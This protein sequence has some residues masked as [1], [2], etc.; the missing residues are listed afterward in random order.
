MPMPAMQV[1]FTGG[2]LSPALYARVDID[3]FSTGARTLKN[4]FVHASG[5][6]SNRTGL[7]YTVHC[8]EDDEVCRLI[9]FTFNTEQTYIL[10][11]QDQTMRVIK[12]DGIVLEP[13]FN[14]SGATQANP[15]VVTTS[16]AHGYA[17]GDEVFISGVGGMS[18]LNERFFIVA[19]VTATTFELQGIDGTSYTAYSSGGTVSRIF[20][21]TTPY[22]EADLFDLKFTQ[23]GDVMTLVHPSYAP[24]DL[25]RTA[26]YIWTLAVISFSPD[27]SAPTGV[28]AA[29]SGTGTGKAYS[30]I[31]TAY[32]EDTGEESIASSAASVSNKDLSNSGDYCTITWS[33]VTDATQYNIYKDEDGSGF[34]GF[35]GSSNNLTFTDRNIQP[36]YDDSPALTTRNPFAAA[37]DY[38]ATT[39][40]HQQR[41]WF[42]QT[43]NDPQKVFGSVSG[44][45]TNMNVSKS[46]RDDD[47]VSA[48]IAGQQINEIRHLVA[49]GQMIVFTAGAEWLMTSSSQSKGLTPSTISFNV[50][51]YYGASDVRPLVIGNTALFITEK[52]N[53]VR[54]INYSLETDGYT[55][56]ELTVLAEHLF[57]DYEI[58]DWTYA[59]APY[60]MV[61]AVRDDGKVLSLTYV[62]EHQVW[63]WTQHDTSGTFESVASVTEG[64]EDAV[65]FVVRRK[66]NGVWKKYI[67]RLHT[68][69]FTDVRDCFFVDSGVSYDN[70]LAV[71]GA[72]QANPVVVTVTGHNY[73]NGDRIDLTDIVGMDELNGLRFK[74]NNVTANTFELQT[75][76]AVPVDIDGTGYTA[77]E[78]GGYSRKAVD[79]VVGLDHLEGEEVSI[80]A[81]GNVISGKTVANGAVSLG[82]YYS[83]VH[84]GLG[85]VSDFETLDVNLQDKRG[86]VHGRRR[87]VKE[88]T[89]RWY[90]SRGGFLGGSEDDLYEIN[91]REFEDWGDPTD[92]ITGDTRHNVSSAWDTSGKLFYRQT[93]PLP[94][95]ILAIIPEV[96]VGDN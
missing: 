45:Y 82:N 51:T 27:I 3:K 6:V 72:T 38:P 39:A 12:D 10:A 17:N 53:Q 90:K 83:R 66:V 23:S 43:D 85:Y 9:P 50:Q 79:S 59:Q 88:A 31:V 21:L 92:L 73:S 91:Q 5:G 26:H 74:V 71:S 60:S 7:K 28:G 68:R 34:Y 1:A 52:A 81:D 32:N 33:S 94:V 64:Q 8:K 63:A 86:L 84:V 13:A 89:I 77:Y 69:R 61:W 14:I 19:N 46:V 11:F 58:N 37:G 4:F 67:E 78:S 35:V 87:Q 22:L 16:A 54:D 75:D 55:G 49:I 65:Y 44:N 96:E 56:N 24:R 20:T 48:V 42:A 93:D 41:R 47:A 80:L 76:E 57:T 2:E 36:E 25:S 40:Y 29:Y 95:T 18:E 30:W 15:V 70:P 62:R